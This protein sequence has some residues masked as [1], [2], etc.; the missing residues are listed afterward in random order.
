MRIALIGY[1]AVARNFHKI[2]EEKKDEIKKRY[3]IVPKIVAICDRGGY[4]H[5]R[6]GLSYEKLIKVKEET[7]TVASYEGGIRGARG[8]DMIDEVEAEVLVEASVA[9]FE[10]GQPALDHIIRAFERR[11]H[12]ITC[13]KP[14]LALAMPSLI[15]MAWHYGV[16][17]LY[18]GTVGGGTPFLSF[19]SRAL[20]GNNV[21]SIRGILN[22]T[23]NYVLTQMLERDLSFEEALKEARRLGYA[24]EDPTLDIGGFDAA[25]KLVILMNHAMG[26]RVTIR[27][28]KISGIEHVTLDM[29]KESLKRGRVIKLIARSSPKPQVSAEEIDVNEPLNVGGTLNAVSF[30]VEGLGEVVL[31]GR[32]AGGRETAC[33]IL[34]DL[35]ELKDRLSLKGLWT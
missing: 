32:G 22:G 21:K 13:N 9:N 24:E 6:R 30:D 8:I 19:T 14:P 25:A 5:S 15:E 26:E 1:G 10:N 20:R 3:G 16:E 29:V 31:I 27:D 35:V 4:V 33:S 23:S 18:S 17:F 2:I 34:R 28:I 11:M 12:V 7:G